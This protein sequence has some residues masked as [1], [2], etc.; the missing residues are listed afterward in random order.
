MKRIKGY[1]R[2]RKE[3]VGNIAIC[4]KIQRKCLNS[5][6]HHRNWLQ[7]LPPQIYL[8]CTI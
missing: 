8:R 4:K 1:N 5:C 7:R 6:T 3:N 2:R